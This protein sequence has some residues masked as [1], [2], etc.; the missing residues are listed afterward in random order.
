MARGFAPERKM[1][2]SDEYSRRSSRIVSHRKRDK[3]YVYGFHR[4]VV[5]VHE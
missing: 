4:L 5:W 3:K 2:G 1:L